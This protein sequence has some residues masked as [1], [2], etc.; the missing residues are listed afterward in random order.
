MF[1]KLLKFFVGEPDMTVEQEAPEDWVDFSYYYRIEPYNP[2]TFNVY[3]CWRV[4]EIWSRSNLPCHER[5]LDK[6]TTME[7]AKKAVKQHR[8]MRYRAWL[9]HKENNPVELYK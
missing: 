3:L 2:N 8:N 4:S 1:S 5:L 6:R 9:F 7:N